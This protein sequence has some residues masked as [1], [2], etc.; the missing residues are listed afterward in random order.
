MTGEDLL[1]RYDADPTRLGNNET[2]DAY[3]KTDDLNYH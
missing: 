3:Y 1:I 2:V